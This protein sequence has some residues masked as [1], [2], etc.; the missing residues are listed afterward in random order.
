MAVGWLPKSHLA[1]GSD[2]K[3]SEVGCVQ[4]VW[5]KLYEDDEPEG[6]GI[7]ISA[8]YCIYIYICMYSYILQRIFAY[9]FNLKVGEIGF[10]TL[11]SRMDVFESTVE[12]I[13]TY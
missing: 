9:F 11:D 5:S 4:L 12:S 2:C 1:V 3:S 7:G 13:S 6:F 10:F 8:V